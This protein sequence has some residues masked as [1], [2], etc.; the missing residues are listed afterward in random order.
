MGIV[1]GVDAGTTIT[2]A[3]A[4]SPDMPTVVTSRATRVEHISSDRYE[5]RQEDVFDSVVAVL[6]DLVTVLGD[7]A[8]DVVAVGVTAQGDGLWLTRED[9]T[10][11]RSAIS[12]MDGRA[13]GIVAEWERDGTHA[14]LFHTTG[15]APFAGSTPALLA[16]AAREEPDTL[17]M[18]RRAWHCKD[19]I[20][21][22]LAG[23]RATD[24]SNAVLF[25]MH[26]REPSAALFDLLGIPDAEQ[27]ASPVASTP[28][29]G[30]LPEIAA[31][32]GLTAGIPVVSAPYDLVASAIGAGASEVGDGLLIVGTT[33]ACEVLASSLPQDEEPVGLTLAT[34]DPDRHWRAMPAMVGAATLDWALGLV[35]HTIQDIPSLLEER[36]TTTARVLP[37][38][39]PAGER[40]PFR[41]PRARGRIDGL[42]LHT[43]AADIVRAVVESLGYSARSCLE[44]AG[45]SGR[46]LICGGGS[47]GPL[48]QAFADVLGRPLEQCTAPEVGALGAAIQAAHAT[49]TPVPASS[50][51]TTITPGHGSAQHYE[52]GYSTYLRDVRS[53]RTL[54]AD[55]TD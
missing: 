46:L 22:Q 13:Q 52:R 7:R 31:R 34:A 9:G 30:L 32:T 54:W 24:H 4:F 10:P 35:G 3:A 37:F 14:Q 16:W 47:R 50:E 55:V 33:L 8:R 27:L 26:R 17:K 6:S 39:A 5:Q 20:A 18:A 25:D 42:T 21:A 15:S 45:L 36:P 53:A 49:G 43:S 38:L 48:A 2:K 11:V 40:A 28:T 1:I 51:T 12:W 44:R 23:I 19:M 41:D 29:G